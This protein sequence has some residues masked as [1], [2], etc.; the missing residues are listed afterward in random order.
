MSPSAMNSHSFLWSYKTH[1]HQSCSAHSKNS[2]WFAPL[3]L[4]LKPLWTRAHRFRWPWVGRDP[5]KGHFV[6]PLCSKQGYF[7]LDQATQDSSFFKLSDLFTCLK[8]VKLLNQQE[9]VRCCSHSSDLFHSCSVWYWVSC[10]YMFLNT[11]EKQAE[12]PMTSEVGLGLAQDVVKEPSGS[13]AI[14]E[15]QPG[16]KHKTQCFLR[17][18]GAHAWGTVPLYVLPDTLC[19]LGPPE[20]N[21][22]HSAGAKIDKDEIKYHDIFS[23]FLVKQKIKQAQCYCQNVHL[24][25]AVGKADS[26]THRRSGLTP[27]LA[28]PSSLLEFHM[29]LLPNQKE[30]IWHREEVGKGLELYAGKSGDL[31][32]HLVTGKLGGHHLSTSH[33]DP[34]PF[35][36]FGGL[37]WQSDTKIYYLVPVKHAVEEFTLCKYQRLS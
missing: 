23:A 26:G 16:F 27:L 6:Q 22:I 18:W 21:K 19:A 20:C 29:Q 37:L 17:G 14:R 10:S 15:P 36:Q 32:N 4:M 7:Q 34:C 30:N 25:T 8:Y 12:N 33:L 13:T 3:P 11:Y 1:Q 24:C 9:A 31:S 2:S 28:V 35:M 5:Q